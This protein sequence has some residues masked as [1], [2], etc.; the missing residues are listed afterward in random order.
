MQN[1]SLQCNQNGQISINFKSIKMAKLLAVN[2]ALETAKSLWQATMSQNGSFTMHSERPN[3]YDSL[4][5]TQN[6][7][8][9]MAVYNALKMAKIIS[10]YN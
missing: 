6:Q 8:I 5:C 1:G 7:Q 10:V 9:P 4:Q 3:S 2:N